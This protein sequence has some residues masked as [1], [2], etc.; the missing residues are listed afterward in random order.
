MIFIEVK[1]MAGV[2]YIR[3]SEVL[4]V[5]YADRERCNVVMVGGVSMACMEAA[6]VV[7]EKITAAL[8]G[9]VAQQVEPAPDAAIQPETIDGDASD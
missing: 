9:A 7:A 2:N 3:A 8:V 1:S 6:A 4:A 5:Q